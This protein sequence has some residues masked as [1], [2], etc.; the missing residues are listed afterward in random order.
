MG[1][2]TAICLSS[3]KGTAK[4][5][6]D[7]GILETGRGFSGDAHAG[8]GDRQVSILPAERIEEFR[9]AGA[10]D[11]VKPGAFGEN[12]VVSGIDFSTLQVGSRLKIGHHVLL[13]ITQFGKECHEKC[14]IGQ[15]MGECVMPKYGIF[16]RV[17][18]GGT[19]RPGDEVMPERVHRVG[20]LTISDSC[21][22]GK[23]EDV[24]GKTLEEILTRCKITTLVVRAIVPDDATAIEAALIQMADIAKV[25]MIITTGGTGFSHRDVTPEV[26]LKVIDRVVPGLPEA[27]RQRGVTA[28]AKAMLSRSVAGIRGACLIINFPGS[29]KAVTE[30]WDAIALALEHGLDVLAGEA[31]DFSGS[32]HVG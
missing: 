1:I 10:G 18:F 4:T 20:V 2:I 11:L 27:M 12:L 13:E 7:V 8:D 16:A 24:S 19:L 28:D 17:L 21:S 30:S 26:T 25:R 6:V 29:P 23:R 32:K 5:P 22:Q 3:S 31:S 14:Q 9:A 15:K